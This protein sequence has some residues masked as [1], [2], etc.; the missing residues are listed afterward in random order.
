[1]AS[2][3]G[4]SGCRAP[5]VDADAKDTSHIIVSR[6]FLVEA[7]VKRL[8]PQLDSSKRFHEEPGVT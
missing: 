5:E 6:V 1:M 8:I 4:V 7:S 3:P 2:R